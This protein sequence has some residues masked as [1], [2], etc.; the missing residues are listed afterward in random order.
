MLCGREVQ[1]R[2]H[3]IFRHKVRDWEKRELVKGIVLTY[4]FSGVPTD[5]LYVCLNIPSVK[6]PRK[7]SIQLPRE[8][9]EQIPSE[10][11]SDMEQICLQNHIKLEI[12][13]YELAIGRAKVRKES[14]GVL[15]Y[16]GASVEEILRF[17]SVGTKIAFQILDLVETRERHW[18]LDKELA[19]FILSRLKEELGENCSWLP[20]GW[21]FVCN[22]LLLHDSNMWILAHADTSTK[23]LDFLYRNHSIR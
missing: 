11:M 18:T 22:P 13:D 4:H 15:Y 2:L 17:A 7:R 9:I 5:S 8:A 19:C 3:I 14:Q 12:K 16:R 1:Q 10:I 21:H 6:E 20:E 23:A